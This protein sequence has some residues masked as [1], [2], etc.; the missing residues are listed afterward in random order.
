[1]NTDLIEQDDA[2]TASSA[3]IH[4]ADT[5]ERPDL[6]QPIHKALRAC[7]ADT[8]FRLG[9]LDIGDADAMHATLAGTE[10]LLA[11]L[12]SHLRHEEQFV[13]PALEA[14]MPGCA[15]S[16]EAEHEAHRATMQALRDAMA[17]LRAAPTEAAALGL[18]RQFALFMAENLSHMHW[19]ETALN[20]RLWLHHDDAQLHA[21]HGRLRASIDPAEMALTLRWM[22]PALNP[23]QRLDFFTALQSEA[24]P[25][26]VRATLEMAQAVLDVPEWA[27]LA[28]GLGRS[29]VPWFMTQ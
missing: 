5:A 28:R 23:A 17:A 9:A 15:A 24:P 18:Y 1:M 8:L 27:K 20:A 13:H 10:S 2:Q 12:A 4:R 25:A 16:T 29:P 7:M 22:L 21:L 6:Y 3:P 19:E 26:A 11:L 14:S